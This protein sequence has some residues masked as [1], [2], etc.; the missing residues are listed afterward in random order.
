MK[1]NLC[2]NSQFNCDWHI[3]KI[4]LLSIFKTKAYNRQSKLKYFGANLINIHLRTEVLSTIL[5][6]I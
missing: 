3:S 1:I 2:L 6:K 4:M 5:H